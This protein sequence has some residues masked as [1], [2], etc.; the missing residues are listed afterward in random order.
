MLRI[1]PIGVHIVNCELSFGRWEKASSSKVGKNEVLIN[2]S[3]PI[4]YARRLCM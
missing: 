3:L 2:E 4:N 1:S